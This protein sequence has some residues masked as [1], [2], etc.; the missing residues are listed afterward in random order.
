[1][2]PTVT[3]KRGN[4][5]APCFLMFVLK[6]AFPP[7]SPPVQCHQTLY[8][9]LS[10]GSKWIQFLIRPTTIFLSIT[11]HV[12]FFWVLSNKTLHIQSKRF[13][14]LIMFTKSFWQNCLRINENSDS[15]Q[16]KC[17]LPKT[18]TPTETLFFNPAD[19]GMWSAAATIGAI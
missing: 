11:N 5:Y 19:G 2:K 12:L 16:S 10:F 3:V 7:C 1:M 18:S 14:L 13:L 8:L 9:G 4:V 6:I 15:S 17:S